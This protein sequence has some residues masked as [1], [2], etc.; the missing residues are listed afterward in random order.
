MSIFE[1][2]LVCPFANTNK[3]LAW[4]LPSGWQPAGKRKAALHD[5]P[6][7]ALQWHPPWA[8]TGAFF[9]V[10]FAA[11]HSRR[12]FFA[13]DSWL[14]PAWPRLLQKRRVKKAAGP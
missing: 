9:V 10:A 12:I 11:L 1:Q 4:P 7:A 8:L 2:Q 3:P 5:S 13:Q 14:C 6:Q